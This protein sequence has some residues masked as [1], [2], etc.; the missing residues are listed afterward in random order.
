MKEKGKVLF[1]ITGDDDVI[2]GDEI[3]RSKLKM[4]MDSIPGGVIQFYYNQNEFDFIYGS[5]GYFKLIGGDRKEYYKK[6]ERQSGVLCWREAILRRRC[7][8]THWIPIN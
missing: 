2:A 6:F 1:D 7:A 4:L 8:S 5:D 3:S